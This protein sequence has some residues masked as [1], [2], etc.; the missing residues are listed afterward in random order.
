MSQE[1]TGPNPE[2][3]RQLSGMLPSYAKGLVE[4]RIQK[5]RP[6][7][8]PTAAPTK[9]CEICMALFD[10][11]FEHKGPVE[12]DVCHKCQKL[13]DEGLTAFITADAYA[14][15]K[16]DSLKDMAGKIVQIQDATMKMMRDLFDVKKRE[17]HDPSKN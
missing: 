2:S 7:P 15:G 11:K 3:L 13:L 16:S 17:Q 1:N 5:N 8:V 12:S 14:F 9:Y 10:R 4:K 6:A